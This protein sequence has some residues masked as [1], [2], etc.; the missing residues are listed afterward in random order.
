[1]YRNHTLI[2][3][4]LSFQ[5]ASVQNDNVKNALEFL[6]KKYVPQLMDLIF[7][8]VVPA[9]GFGGPK[10]RKQRLSND[11]SEFFFKNS[12]LQNE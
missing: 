9:G 1:M 8:G 10:A 2:R 5:L 4:L 3:L 6:F 11:S 12:S 7:E